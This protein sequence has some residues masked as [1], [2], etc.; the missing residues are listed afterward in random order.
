M[1]SRI[2]SAR[3]SDEVYWSLVTDL[4]GGASLV[5]G[6]TNSEYLDEM[7]AL[8]YVP[9]EELVNATERMIYWDARTYLP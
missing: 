8:I 4:P 3:N 1:A 2:L 5:K 7:T 6:M 9:S